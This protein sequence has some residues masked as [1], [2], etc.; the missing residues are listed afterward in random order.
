MDVKKEKT[1]LVVEDERP[2]LEAIKR[3]LEINGFL[4]VTARSTDQAY[5]YVEDIGTIDAI[6]LD[7]YLLGK[8]SGLDFVAKCKEEGSSCKNIPIYVVSNTASADKVQTYLR[9]GITKYFVKA[10]HRLDE[11]INQIKMYLEGEDS[12]TK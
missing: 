11:I 2:L 8:E 5:E 12:D 10:E 1:I 6:W 4:V 9:F 7:H 3:K